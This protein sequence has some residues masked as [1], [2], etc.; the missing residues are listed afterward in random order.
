MRIRRLRYGCAAL[1]AAGILLLTG[2]SAP[3]VD[4]VTLDKDGQITDEV[5]ALGSRRAEV[6]DA[7]KQLDEDENIQLYVAYVRN[8]AGRG[9]QS[10]ADAT[11]QKNGLGQ[12]DILLAVATRDRQ[13]AV[14]AAE[15]SG[16]TEDQ[17]QQVNAEAIEPPLRQNDWAGAA[18]GGAN[19]FAAVLEGK[20]IPK[21][22]ITPG[23]ANPGGGAGA[24]QFTASDALVPILAVGGA[25]V[26]AGYLFSPKRRKRKQQG[27]GGWGAPQLTPLP[28]LDSQA[29]TLL[30]ETDDAIRTSAEEL[31]FA[32][33]QFGEGA[34]APFNEAIGYA[35][36]S[37]TAA[38]RLRQQ[39]DDAYPEDDATKRKMLDEIIARC[40]DANHRLDAES[41][42][43]DQLRSMVAKAPEVLANA[44][45]AAERLPGRI[46]DAEEK[47]AGLAQAYAS[48]A[49][50]AVANHPREAKDRFQFAAK[51][52]TQAR[53]ALTAGDSNTTAVHVR[54]AEGA[55][56]QCDTLTDAVLR[57]ADELQTAA[58]KVEEAFRDMQADLADARGMVSGTTH[59]VS[60]ADLQG[61]IARA[62]TVL[63]EVRQ[64]VS[65]GPYD[66]M[67]T[68]RRLE[69]ADAGLEEALSGAREREA[70]ERKARG[71]LDQAL[72]A[73]RS[74]V[75]AARDFITTHRGGIGSAARTR[76]HEAERHLQQ[77]EGFAESDA[78]SALQHAQQADSL[79]R[80]ARELAERDIYGGYGSG[81]GSGYGQM[82]GM[83]RGGP[84]VIVGGGGMGTGMLGGIILGGMLGGG[85][86]GG[87]FGGGGF[88]G[89]PGS[90][91][92]TGTIGR[93]GGGGRF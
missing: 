82:G 23:P 3:T 58:A 70:A 53:T 34:A 26:A 64:A 88:G 84:R 27:A 69:E 80:N 61:R 11:A 48:S 90:F 25:A 67:D 32:S 43:F 15:N 17:I 24:E 55:I 10:W 2:A 4:P 50:A 92:G 91:G 73:A 31:G 89:G 20:P 33:A 93:M 21:P 81:Y 28:E 72:L 38:F 7:L 63:A 54:A 86:R 37:L 66:P 41:T 30:V 19:G 29:R 35:K 39:L 47:L 57:R 8:F 42:A 22:E 46:N 65:A 78:S 62:E 49:F 9:G 51:N 12:N 44:E 79:G 16:F 83:G 71:L 18:I 68:L 13:Y 56:E 59:D 76:L 40:T 77:A 60:T 52:L 85:G 14:S 75:A 6:A 1:G 36:A 45:A 74:E 5:G 87:G